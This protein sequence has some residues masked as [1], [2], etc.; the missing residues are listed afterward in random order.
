[1]R[2]WILIV[3]L[4]ATSAKAQRPESLLVGPGDLVHIQIFDT[5][6]LDQR[7]RVT[8]SGKVSLLVG[9]DVKVS[10]LTPAEAARSIEK[11]LR[12]GDFILRPRVAVFVEEYATQKVSVL[13]EV[14]QPGAYA[15]STPR[16]VLDVLTL[17]GGLTELADRK[18]VVERQET[19][20]KTSYY[21]SNKAEVA[22]DTAV[23]I[24]PGDTLVVPKAGIVYVLGDVKMPGGY[25]MTNNAAQLSV[26]ELCARAGG[27]NHTAVPS[28]ARL[29]RRS[30]DGSYIDMALSLSDIQK[31]KK[32]DMNLQADDVV[33]VPFSYLRNFAVSAS[34]LV[35]S[36]SSAAIYRF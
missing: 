18:I 6:E 17:A 31:G 30:A 23:R 11:V 4:I 29:I 19:G 25:T 9:G 20:E 14:K 34:G 28:H 16:S 8:D 10:N 24:N 35:A 12:D 2:S 5:P 26:L 21:V 33:Y 15:I 36:A 13:G 3:F 32:S 7:T 27:T 1:M 22:I